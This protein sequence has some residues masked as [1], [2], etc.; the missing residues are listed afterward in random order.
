MEIEK[1]YKSAIIYKFGNSTMVND[2]FPIETK[3]PKRPWISQIGDIITK[4]HLSSTK[5][6]FGEVIFYK[7]R[8]DFD[9]GRSLLLPEEGA[10]NE[11]EV[12]SFVAGFREG[13]RIR[14]P[15]SY[16]WEMVEVPNA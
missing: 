3:N 8:V 11:L 5:R 16:N 4:Q 13:V 2:G 6:R 12:D 14:L 10:L 9:D 7:I 1:K 15:C